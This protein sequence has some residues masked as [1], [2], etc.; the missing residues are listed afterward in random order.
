MD[1][2]I[3]AAITV[4]LK[5]REVDVLTVQEDGRDRQPDPLVLDRATQLDRVTVTSDHDFLR[6]AHQR[7]SQGT[8]F[9]GVIFARL[10]KMSIGEI[11][12]DLHLIAECGHADEFAN[13]VLYLPL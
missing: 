10:T 1:E 8:A 6:E 11:V 3:P 13:E 12:R 9:G 2:H 7:Q 4:S 5:M